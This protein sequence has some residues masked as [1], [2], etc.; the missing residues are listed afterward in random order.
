MQIH[1]PKILVIIIL[2]ILK[3]NEVLISPKLL[4]QQ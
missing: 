4:W 2:Y 3:M 1:M